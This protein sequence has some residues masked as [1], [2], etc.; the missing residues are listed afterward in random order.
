[1]TVD[2]MEHFK[3][4][5]DGGAGQTRHCVQYDFALTQMAQ[6]KFANDKRMRQDRARIEQRGEG[7]VARPEMVDP[8]GRID[9]ITSNLTVAAAAPSG[10][11][12]CRPDAPIGVRFP[13]Q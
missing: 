3:V 8:Y 4:F 12:D 11:A 5:G 10:R 7:L 2:E 13:A 9:Q 1:M 6:G